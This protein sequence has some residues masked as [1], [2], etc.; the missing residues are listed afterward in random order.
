MAPKPY[1]MNLPKKV[2]V[3]VALVVGLLLLLGLAYLLQ[4][5][6][7]EAFENAKVVLTYYYLPSCGYC[8]Q[9]KPVWSAFMREIANNKSIMVREG[10]SAE[11]K[12]WKA[13]D[14]SKPENAA[15]V[16]EKGI[17][18]FPTVI[19]TENGKDV[20]FEGDRTVENLRTFVGIA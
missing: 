5:K 14:G 4:R 19:K 1:M 16:R 13:I 18:G 2:R 20:T 9:F 15:E 7:K 6:K 11:E 8:Q 17:T 12:E 10:K 3:L